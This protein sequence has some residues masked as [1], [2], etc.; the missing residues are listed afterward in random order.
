[1][2]LGIQ[3]QLLGSDGKRHPSH[4]NLGTFYAKKDGTS[5]T[6]SSLWTV[7][8]LASSGL[9]WRKYT[10]TIK[11]CGDEPKLL[12]PAEETTTGEGESWSIVQTGTNSVIIYGETLPNGLLRLGDGS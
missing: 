9:K 12:L 11:Q 3:F 2:D 8:L 1:L 4:L 5:F 7:D 6:H 10:E